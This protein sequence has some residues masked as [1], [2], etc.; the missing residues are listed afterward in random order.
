MKQTKPYLL[1]LVSV[2]LIISIGLLGATAYLY[3][4]N[5]NSNFAGIVSEPD[6]NIITQKNAAISRDSLEKIYSSAIVSYDSSGYNVM[7]A[8][9]VDTGAAALNSN[10]RDSYLDSLNNKTQQHQTFDKLRTE[11]DQ[12]LLDK[13]PSADLNLAKSKIN[14]LKQL[15]EGLKNKNNTIIKENDR[16]FN[17]V[18]QMSVTN[19]NTTIKPLYN[20]TALTATSSK[21]ITFNAQTSTL[22]VDNIQLNAYQSTNFIDKETNN[23]QEADKMIGTVQ[24]KNNGVKT[25]VAEVMVVVTQP[26]GKVLQNS[27]WE[28]GVFNTNTGKKIYSNKL[29]FDNT[30]ETTS[31]KINFALQADTYMPGNYT[32]ELYQNGVLI[33]KTIK[34]FN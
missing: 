30:F 23:T 20:N 29:R 16:L 12:I 25:A 28:S 8:N 5:G 26:N 10:T 32:V 1:V 13:S 2:F 34:S 3:F 22:K 4:Y 14:E 9:F 33:A 15:N 6:N 27:N 24:I 7:P 19:S 21:T 31:K 11:I 18:K 17:M